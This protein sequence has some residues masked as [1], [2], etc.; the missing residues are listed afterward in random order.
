PDFASIVNGMEDSPFARIVNGFGLAGETSIHDVLP[1]LYQHLVDTRKEIAANP[2]AFLVHGG[3]DNHLKLL[4]YAIA[5]WNTPN[6]QAAL[7]KLAQE[8]ARWNLIKYGTHSLKGDFS[9]VG[10]LGMPIYGLPSFPTL[11]L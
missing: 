5:N 2:D 4:D 3:A 1:A 10:F 6:R 7:D 8:E 11:T 9:D